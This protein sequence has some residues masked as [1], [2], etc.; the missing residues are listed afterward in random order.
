MQ[1][2]E[3]ETGKE[4]E[5]RLRRYQ[6]LLLKASK[7]GDLDTLKFLL[8]DYIF[9][10]K[11]KNILTNAFT[12]VHITQTIWDFVHVPELDI[13]HQE[14]EEGFEQEDISG[15]D[16]S[17]HFKTLAENAYGKG[18]KFGSEEYMEDQHELGDKAHFDLFKKAD[19]KK[20]RMS[21]LPKFTTEEYVCTPKPGPEGSP[22]IDFSMKI[23][24]K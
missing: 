5:K 23:D 18:V 16:A 22:S 2:V 1:G 20:K 9:D 19:H 12:E 4:K 8:A 10:R 24:R 15:K 13:N 3:S 6:R 14:T 7:T 21:V 11:I 17:G